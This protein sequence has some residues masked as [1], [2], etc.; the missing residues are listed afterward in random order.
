MK[1]KNS[2]KK[3]IFLLLIIA[4][5]LLPLILSA[6]IS[7]LNPSFYSAEF[8]KYGV[9]QKYPDTNLNVY[10]N[11]VLDYL[12]NQRNAMPVDIPL[13]GREISHMAD[14]KNVFSGLFV[15]SAVMLILIL[16][17][18]ALLVKD[19]DALSI[20]SNALR[21]G[22]TVS[23]ILSL[24]LALSFYYSFNSSFVIFHSLFFKG[25]SWLFES[26]DNIVN[27]YPEGLFFDIS[28]RLFALSLLFATIL[29]AAGSLMKKFKS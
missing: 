10:N 6:Y 7:I 15:F 25:N 1:I 22:G 12:T 14:V 16:I 21:C 23:I 2:P 17:G 4:F 27:I 3:I 9:N 20:F 29:A 18:I 8:E 26:A 11:N 13:N 5:A 24:I 19:K 28:V